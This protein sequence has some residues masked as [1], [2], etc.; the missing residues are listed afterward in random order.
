MSGGETQQ[1]G[2][3]GD[4][5]DERPLTSEDE[6]IATYLSPLAHPGALDF[7][8]DAAVLV[9]PADH[10]LVITTDAVV[11]GVHF[12]PQDRPEDIAAKVVAVNLSD[13]VAKGAWPVLGYQMVLSLPKGTTHGWMRRF[14]QGLSEWVVAGEK[15]G[16]LGGDV[17]STSGPLTI[18]ITAIGQIP[19]GQTVRRTGA[20]AGD[21]V[22]LLGQLG[23]SSLG[24]RYLQDAPL[25][26]RHGLSAT[27]VQEL[28][29]CYM[30]P[31]ITFPEA[32]AEAIRQFAS[33][34]LDLSDGLVRDVGRLAKASG[35]GI[36]IDTH[37]VPLHPI[38]AQLIAAGHIDLMD[39]LTGGDD[40]MPLVTV[41]QERLE[42]FRAFGE[43]NEFGLSDRDE[44]GRVTDGPVGLTLL[45]AVGEPI[46]L[47][48]RTGWD[49]M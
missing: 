30:A 27:D 4:L 42:A 7:K 11:A 18:A 17:V 20:R 22:F 34:S 43:A 48:G 28:V 5:T 13:L 21:H 12:F 25:G 31:A 37:R 26:K 35:V 8:D 2:G 32:Y 9:P 3:A 23:G 40:Y 45:S 1:V 33:S 49:H 47:P 39:V 46:S 6:L 10:D 44:I 19:S 24:L 38:A 15:F 41:P 29:R 14:T 16:L 36:E